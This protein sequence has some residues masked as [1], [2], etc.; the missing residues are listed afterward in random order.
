MSELKLVSKNI[1]SN[2]GMYLARLLVGLLAL[3]ACLNAYGQ[4]LYGLYLI[5]FGLSTS[6]AA[7]DFGSA[8]SIFRYVVEHE[9]DKDQSKLANALSIGV[10]FNLLASILIVIVLVFAGIYSNVLFNLSADAQK[11]SITL[12]SLAAINAVLLTIS[13]I[14]VNILNGNNCFHSRNRLQFIPVVATLLLVIYLLTHSNLS[15]VYFSAAM[16]CISLLSLILDLLLVKNKNLIKGIP[17]RLI[18]NRSLFHSKN[19][20]YN[21]NVFILSFVSFLAVQADKLVIASFFSVASVTVYAIITKP[22][23][24]LKGFLAITYP[25]IQPQLSKYNLQA[26]RDN[27]NLFSTKIIQG[28]FILFLLGI[29]FLS[30]FFEEALWIWLRST[31]YNIYISWGVLSMLALAITILYGPYYRTLIYTDG[32]K[33]ILNFS[34]LSVAINLVISIIL[35][36]WIGFPGVII[37]TFTQILLEFFYTNYL[38]TKIL[39]ADIKMIYQ[40]KTMISAVGILIFSILIYLV[41]DQHGDSSAI[42]I[43]LTGIT[44]LIYLFFINYFIRSEKIHLI[45]SGK[46]DSLIPLNKSAE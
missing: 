45:F 2:Y 20:V 26:T 39:R 43:I 4:E 46:Q 18:L 27:F 10:T 28:S 42:L 23:F 17:I 25:V 14:P 1:F 22:Y 40:S 8:K 31:E 24:L 34:Y 32:I 7:F 3:P 30:I 38:A 21:Y 29:S 11:Y 15:L 37:G 6:L 35:T 16:V 5:C 12:F 41:K 36:S 19:I 13:T 9:N 33:K 44:S